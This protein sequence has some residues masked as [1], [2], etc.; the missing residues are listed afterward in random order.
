MLVGSLDFLREM[1]VHLPDAALVPHA[2]YTA[3]DG[4]LA[5]VCAMA[6]GKLKGVSAGLATLASQRKLS[7]MLVSNNFLLTDVFIREKFAVP[8]KRMIFATCQQRAET[9][10]WKPD[11]EQRVICGLSTQESIAATAFSITGARALRTAMRQGTAVHILGG[12]VGLAIVAVLQFVDG[13]S[14]LTPANL[15]LF[16]LIWAIPGLLMTEW[17]RGL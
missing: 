7:P 4:E 8:T 2:V 9:A 15:L 14:L 6:F 13:G 5:S 17:T 11:P 16:E 1:G 12:I 10:A 3:I